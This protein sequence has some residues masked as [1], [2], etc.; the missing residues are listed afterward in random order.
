MYIF[1]GCFYFIFC[2]IFEEKIGKVSTQSKTVVPAMPTLLKTVSNK[3]HKKS[4]SSV[5]ELKFKV[6]ETPTLQQLIKRGYTREQASQ[7]YEHERKHSIS[8]S[9]HIG[10]PPPPLSS[11]SLGRTYNLPA[12]PGTGIVVGVGTSPHHT[13]WL[14]FF[15]VDVQ[16][17]SMGAS[18]SIRAE[19]LH[20]HTS[21][22]TRSPLRITRDEPRSLEYHPFYLVWVWTLHHC[23]LKK[24]MS[25]KDCW[26]EA[27]AG[28][29]R[30]RSSL[31]TGIPPLPR[32]S[33]RV[34]ASVAWQ[35]I[36]AGSTMGRHQQIRPCILAALRYQALIPLSLIQPL[37][38]WY[39]IILFKTICGYNLMEHCTG[40][41]GTSPAGKEIDEEVI[42]SLLS[43]GYSRGQLLQVV[44]IQQGLSAF[45]QTQRHH[46]LS[47]SFE[48]INGW[49]LK[50]Y[51][52]SWSIR[53]R[54]I[55]LFDH[56]SQYWPVIN[57]WMYVV[58]VYYSRLQP[59]TRLQF[60]YWS[61]EAILWRGPKRSTCRKW[62]AMRRSWTLQWIQ[63]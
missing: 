49:I 33:V 52:C 30:S 14:L 48:S 40:F 53:T 2:G 57:E 23:H 38:T 18:I 27:T 61:V 11:S 7:L 19:C 32:V 45:K 43:R 3:V 36:A 29:Q 12:A 28:K 46:N 56:R 59:L 22:C 4:K 51:Q 17:T 13:K 20:Y 62:T 44:V 8:Q 47:N 37:R 42:Q 5:E 41:Q 1:K 10:L 25:S 39:Y 15:D 16:G 21:S 6:E 9:A 55:I 31:A 60:I 26:A 34:A 35:E 50:A 24:P 58:R 63:E 54:S